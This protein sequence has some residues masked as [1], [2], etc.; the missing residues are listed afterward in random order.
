MKG[1]IPSFVGSDIHVPLTNNVWSL[2]FKFL[3]NPSQGDVISLFFYLI[4]FFE[5]SWLF[6]IKRQT[7]DCLVLGLTELH[8]C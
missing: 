8:Q 5:K 6:L 7:T 1:T 4:F 2:V 3:G